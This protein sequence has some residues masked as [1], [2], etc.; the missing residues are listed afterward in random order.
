MKG[1]HHPDHHDLWIDPLN[2]RRMIDSNDGGV[3][4]TTNGGATWFMPPMPICQFY[5]ISV[6]NSVPYRVMGTMQDQGTASG[7]SNKIL[8]PFTARDCWLRSA[9]TRAAT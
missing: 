6:D 2:P 1:V 5:H 8:A 9:V 4:I 7:P 3:D